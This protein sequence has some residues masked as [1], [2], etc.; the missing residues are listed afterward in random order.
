MARGGVGCAQH[1]AQ[2]A[3]ERASQVGETLG[4]I[5][6]NTKDYIETKT[7]PPPPP[8]R[9]KFLGAPQPPPPPLLQHMSMA[10]SL[11]CLTALPSGTRTSP[12]YLL[13][14]RPIRL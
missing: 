7:T 8:P 5:S 13:L 3:R 2:R 1:D 12:F 14:S 11:H 4:E 6:K 10:A 9:R